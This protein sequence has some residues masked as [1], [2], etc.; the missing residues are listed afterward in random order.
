MDNKPQ[1]K[2]D[3]LYQLLRE[4]KIEEFN[5]RKAK[6]ESC[7][8]TQCD[9]RSVDLRGID[10]DGLDFSDGYF[11]QADLRGV[12]LRQATM[13]GASI[14]GARISGTYFPSQLTADEIGLSL[15]HGIRMRYQK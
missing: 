3:P 2:S 4:G 7:D 10:A 9:F 13:A 14:N 12:D 6:G 5:K 15:V 1:I 11:H 8:L